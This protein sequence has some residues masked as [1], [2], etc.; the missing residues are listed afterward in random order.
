MFRKFCLSEKEFNAAVN[1]AYLEGYEAGKRDG[2]RNAVERKVTPN[3]LREYLGLPKIETQEAN[4][5]A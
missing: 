1:K 3:M 2:F 4:N 5:G